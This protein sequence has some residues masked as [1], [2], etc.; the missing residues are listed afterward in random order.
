MKHHDN[1]KSYGTTELDVVSSSYPKGFQFGG[2]LVGC[3]GFFNE[4]LV[5]NKAEKSV[6]GQS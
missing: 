3:F 6:V 5:E 2:F 1:N 4:Y